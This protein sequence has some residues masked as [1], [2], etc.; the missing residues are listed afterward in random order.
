MEGKIMEERSKES[1]NLETKSSRG[2]VMKI[3]SMNINL[4]K[5]YVQRVKWRPHSK[6]ALC[7]VFVC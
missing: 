6:I 1:S 4:D 7:G 3:K 5:L 2:W